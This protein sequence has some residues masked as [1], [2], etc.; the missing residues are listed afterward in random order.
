[1][2]MTSIHVKTVQKVINSHS[3]PG[4]CSTEQEIGSQDV[5]EI[6]GHQIGT[7]IILLQSCGMS[8]AHIRLTCFQ[9][10]CPTTYGLEHGQR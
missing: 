7:E 8:C 10:K 2:K 3:N 5:E 6:I 9:L 4:G 1:M